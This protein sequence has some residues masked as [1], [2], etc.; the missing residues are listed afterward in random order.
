MFKPF[1]DKYLYYFVSGS[2][3]KAPSKSSTKKPPTKKAK[4]KPVYDSDSDFN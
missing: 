1:N 2:K 4:A 3:K